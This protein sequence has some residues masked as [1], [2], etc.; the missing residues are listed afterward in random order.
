MKFPSRASSAAISKKFLNFVRFRRLWNF[1][2]ETLCWRFSRLDLAQEMPRRWSRR[3][4][5]RQCWQLLLGFV[6]S[7][8][9]STLLFIRRVKLVVVELQKV[10]IDNQLNRPNCHLMRNTRVCRC[11]KVRSIHAASVSSRS[12]PGK[13]KEQQASFSKVS[14]L[15]FS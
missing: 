3:D 14:S 10:I 11:K 12:S 6:E 13:K 5:S 15:R 2:T 4:T 8:E 9:S 1:Q 7:Y